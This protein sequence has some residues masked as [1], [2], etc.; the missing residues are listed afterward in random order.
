[1]DRDKDHRAR[2]REVVRYGLVISGALALIAIVGVLAF[3][4]PFHHGG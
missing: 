1:M 3:G 4:G 2:S